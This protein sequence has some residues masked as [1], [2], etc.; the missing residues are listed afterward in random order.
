MGN[1]Y[2]KFKKFTIWHDKCA[3]KV[4]TDGVLLGAWVN[5]D[6]ART[7]LDIGAG[8]G[9][10]S[11]MIAQRCMADIVAVEID[12][13]AAKQCVENI[14]KSPW[15]NRIIV[16]NDDFINCHFN[17]KFDIIVSNPPYFIDSLASPTC[18][19]NM[20]RH[21]D[22]LNF[23]D[24]FAKVSNLLES[25]GEFSIIIPN[26]IVDRVEHIAAKYKLFAAK[27]L[28]V[29]PT[30]NSKVKRQIISFRF[31]TN[32]CESEELVLEIARHKYTREYINLTSFF[33]INM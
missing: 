15:Q 3:M 12:D 29:Y 31:S 21:N 19:R 24:M 20:A 23:A 5:L 16:K 13:S 22:S 17:E 14:Y 1:P 10:V 9:L 30:L 25:N 18:T 28:L 11:L 6:N 7:V 26:D 27:R 33:Y 2:F 4:G 32:D 8:T